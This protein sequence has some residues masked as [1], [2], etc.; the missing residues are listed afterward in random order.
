MTSTTTCPRSS[1]YMGHLLC[2][3]SYG[4][5]SEDEIRAGLGNHG[6]AP[7]VEWKK[8]KIE[9]DTDGATLWYGADLPKTQY[10]VER[11]VSVPRGMRVVRVREWVENLAPFD[12]PINWMQ[13]AT[14]GPPFVEPGKTALDVSATRGLV[15]GGRPG[16]S[17]LK[18]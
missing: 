6:E 12:R 15:G 8:S 2:F 4:P 14:F 9:I 5:P 10:R 17:S 3:P 1:P 11:A 13:H 18:A 7:I 16:A